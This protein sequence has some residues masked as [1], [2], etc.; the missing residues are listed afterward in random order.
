MSLQ[1]YAPFVLASA[2][3]LLTPGPTNTILAASSAAMGL[4][5]SWMLP[6]AE[7][8]GYAVAVLAFVR[9]AEYLADVQAALP[10]M[11]GIAA[12]WLLYS[13]YKLWAQPV[14]QRVPSVGEAMKRVF[15]TTLLNP[16]AMLVGT[17]IIPTALPSQPMS[18]VLL[19]PCLSIMAGVLWMTIGSAIPGRLRPYA[20]K[21]AACVIG[22]FS[23]AAVSS[24]AQLI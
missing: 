9:A 1:V 19:F 17:I 7:A 5:R 21:G 8:A 18:G 2:A 6:L 22:I 13:A 4:R 12:A 20:Y 23:F 3:L 24:A 11:K 10:T 16:K 15:L 14:D